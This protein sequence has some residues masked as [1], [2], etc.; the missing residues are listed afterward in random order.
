M[1]ELWTELLKM[2]FNEIEN[3][4]VSRLRTNEP[5]YRELWEQR[6]H[7]LQQHPLIQ[8][9]SE[10]N[11]IL[12]PSRLDFDAWLRSKTLEDQLNQMERTAIYMQGH[13]DG[14][15]YFKKIGAL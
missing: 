15:A 13:A 12:F 5:V 14:Y 3:E 6:L 10:E 11:R 9:V 2:G 7:L 4:V 8:S 1:L